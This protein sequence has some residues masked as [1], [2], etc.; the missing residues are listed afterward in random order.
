[1]KLLSIVSLAAVMWFAA[2]CADPLEER[3]TNEVGAQLERGITGQGRIGPV[4]RAEDDP[5]A[6]HSV[7]D[8]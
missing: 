1:M 3:T 6:K 2:G 4:Q 8:Q 5:A 7:Q